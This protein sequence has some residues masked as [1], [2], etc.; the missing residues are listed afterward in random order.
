M[1]EMDLNSLEYISRVFKELPEEEKDY[2]LNTARSLLKVQG[3][4]SYPL[5]DYTVTSM[6]T[7]SSDADR[8]I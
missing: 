6:D 7:I 1:K 5:D 4:N 3:D 2:V 8:K